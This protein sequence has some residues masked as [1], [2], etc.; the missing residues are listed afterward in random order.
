[1]KKYLFFIISLFSSF[2]VWAQGP[3]N[4]GTY[5]QGADG[6]KAEELKTALFSIISNHTIQS[7]TPGVWN[8]INAYDVREDGKIWDIYSNISNFTPKTERDKGEGWDV[9]AQRYNR[10]HAMPK[11]WFKK[12]KNQPYNTTA[13]YPIVTTLP[14]W[15]PLRLPPAVPHPARPYQSS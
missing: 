10:E 4:T 14:L 3:N 11:S 8:A 6:K 5:Y 15:S 9:E 1:M 7:Y 2:A 13:V 12:D